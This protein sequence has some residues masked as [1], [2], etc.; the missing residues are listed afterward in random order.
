M[1]N[2][3]VLTED[4]G[5]DP[6]KPV[7]GTVTVMGNDDGST[8]P[9]R[10]DV[11]DDK[12]K[13]SLE[14]PNEG[15]S[16]VNKGSP[17]TPSDKQPEDPA[18]APDKRAVD[19]A[20]SDAGLDMDKLAQEWAENGAL[21]EESYEA[22][23]KVGITKEMVDAYAAGQQALAEK[24][25][26]ELESYVGGK[27]TFEGIFKWAADALSPAEKA[28]ANYALASGDPDAAKLVLDGLKARYEAT[29][30]NTPGFIRGEAAPVSG[31]ITP[32]A[33]AAELSAAMRDPRYTE[34]PAY[35]D[36][37]YKRLAIS[38]L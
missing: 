7:E 27:E 34:D 14:R 10:V 11:L 38:S 3:V 18:E 23:A 17:E 30:G 33:S 25:T 15:T 4:K 20:V 21:S 28:A 16:E 37:V 8:G 5:P 31:G 35:R 26:A 36:R 6:S 1:A 19:K 22:L 13:D 29:M 32:F 9:V 2:K 24:Y 12:P